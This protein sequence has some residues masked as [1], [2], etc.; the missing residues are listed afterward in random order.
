MLED[1]SLL[2][3][4]FTEFEE[5]VIKILEA[6][7]VVDKEFNAIQ[8]SYEDELKELER[9]ERDC[10]EEEIRISNEN[11]QLITANKKLK[12]HKS[13]E[14]EQFLNYIIELGIATGNLKDKFKGKRN[15]A[16]CLN[17]TKETLDVLSEKERLINN[18]INE[19]EMIEITGDKKLIH[20][21]EVD[22]KKANKRDKQ[23]MIKQKQDQIDNMKRQKA[24]E[25]AQRVVIKGRKV[26]KDYPILKEKKKKTNDDGQN[27]FD[28]YAMLHYSSDENN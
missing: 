19:I 26:P 21:I 27:E 18:Y 23:L 28:D 7:Q 13:S 17:F 16:D 6:K 24:V 8:K 22:R 5:K 15:I 11:N 14:V 3:L 4:K 10:I 20:D 1:E 2:I 25:R 9:R 12:L